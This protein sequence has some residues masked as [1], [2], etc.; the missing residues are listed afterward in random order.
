MFSEFQPDVYIPDHRRIRLHW[1]ASSSAVVGGAESGR[2]LEGLNSYDLEC[3]TSFWDTCQEA[4]GSHI[5]LVR[6]NAKALQ[7]WTELPSF[8]AV[9]NWIR[10][11]LTCQ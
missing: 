5:S 11:R 7:I 6:D 2:P 10:R 9:K 1:H 3:K 8:R 4:N